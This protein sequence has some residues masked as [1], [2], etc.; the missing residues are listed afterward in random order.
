MGTC[1]GG[2]KHK[3][4]IRL[5]RHPY[6]L[7]ERR[8]RSSD[9]QTDNS[10]VRPSPIKTANLAA[11]FSA[12]P[13]AGGPPVP[14]GCQEA[15]RRNTAPPG[16]RV[17]RRSFRTRFLDSRSFPARIMH[18]RNRMIQNIRRWR[19]E[20]KGRYR[21][22]W[23]SPGTIWQVRSSEYGAFEGGGKESVWATAW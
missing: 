14:H 15:I 20:V 9:S 16:D 21:L 22:R 11:Q 10:R 4:E 3:N 1:T 17:Q 12:L 5:Q 18:H 8:S 13:R 23:A 7:E 6:S 19:S 2:R